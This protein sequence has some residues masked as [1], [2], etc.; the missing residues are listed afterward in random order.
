[1]IHVS[2]NKLAID[3]NEVEWSF[4]EVNEVP[5]TINK[6]VASEEGTYK[7]SIVKDLSSLIG[8]DLSGVTISFNP[9]A[10]YN[11]NGST[12]GDNLFNIS[13][14]AI[15]ITSG[16]YKLIVD[17]PPEIKIKDGSGATLFTFYTYGMEGT[18]GTTTTGSY[19]YTF[20]ND[21]GV[22]TNVNCAGYNDPPIPSSYP[23][24]QV[25]E[26]A[27]HIITGPSELLT[28]LN[29]QPY[30]SYNALTDNNVGSSNIE[31]PSMYSSRYTQVL[32]NSSS[33]PQWNNKLVVGLPSC[34]TISNFATDSNSCDKLISHYDYTS[35]ITNI[36]TT[37]YL[38]NAEYGLTVS[39][40]TTNLPVNV[41]TTTRIH[42]K[43]KNFYSSGKSTS[44]P[45]IVQELTYLDS[46]NKGRKFERVINYKSSTASSCDWGIWYETTA[47][48]LILNSKDQYIGGTKTFNGTQNFCGTADFTMP[49]AFTYSGIQSNAADSATS[50]WFTSS[51][52]AGRPVKSD[53]F[54]YNPK[55]HHLQVGTNSTDAVVQIAGCNLEYNSSSKSVSFNFN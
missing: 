51:S 35:A 36:N 48:E 22:I 5:T 42:L 55:N 41:T 12:N 26:S 20:P 46:T 37:S 52:T 29:I 28:R 40:S 21:A 19:D 39:S 30:D 34:P 15:F 10:R 50:I 9:D 53:E 16:G 14:T 8:Y 2:G 23:D 32:L 11:G 33:A 27:S 45:Y 3:K 7:R 54:L 25:F 24:E 4:P 1:M 31:F 47:Y 44:Y 17:G 18:Q 49:A 38:A 6:T 43:N 13:I